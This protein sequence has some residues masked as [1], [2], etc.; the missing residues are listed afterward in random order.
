M[1]A[2]NFVKES[3]PVLAGNTA[4]IERKL[5]SVFVEF[6]LNKHV[7][8][9]LTF[10]LLHYKFKIPVYNSNAHFNSKRMKYLYEP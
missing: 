3:G 10:N 4:P 9:S 2:K 5:W 1:F 6:N 8:I 7:C